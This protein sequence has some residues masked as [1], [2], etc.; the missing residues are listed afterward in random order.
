[1]DDFEKMITVV[2][3]SQMGYAPMVAQARRRRGSK[4]SRKN[5]SRMR[6]CRCGELFEP[7]PW[8][9]KHHKDKLCPKCAPS[10]PRWSSAYQSQRSLRML[11]ANYR[12]EDCGSKKKLTCHHVDGDPTNHALDNLRILC[13]ACHQ[14]HT[15]LQRAVRNLGAP[16][17]HPKRR[18]KASKA[19][20]LT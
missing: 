16:P 20:R 9:V 8:Q 3:P 6:I 1:M 19:M 14:P 10:D 7:K 13:K 17:A 12:C 15:N 5:V 18:A 2:H 4:R 11:K